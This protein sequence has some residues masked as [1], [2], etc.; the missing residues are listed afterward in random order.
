M[1]KSILI[2]FLLCVGMVAALDMPI[3]PEKYAGMVYVNGDPAREDSYIYVKCDDTLIDYFK[4]IEPIW[5]KYNY[6]IE[7]YDL[8]VGSELTWYYH[9][10]KLDIIDYY[11]E[12]GFNVPYDIH[13]KKR[14][15][16]YR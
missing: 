13:V 6:V 3:I 10:Q 15:H 2:V 5:N 7:V 8:P 16:R 1:K 12:G 4:I 9:G 11:E 14:T